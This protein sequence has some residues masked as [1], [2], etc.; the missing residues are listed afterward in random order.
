M[1]PP[2]EQIHAVYQRL[3]AQEADAPSDFIELL[4]DPLIAA[5]EMRFPSLPDPDLISDVVTDTLILFVQTPEQYQP[6]RGSLWHYLF[7]DAWGDIQ[8]AVAKEHRRRTKIVS[9]DPVAHDRADGNNIEEEVV[10]RLEFMSRMGGKDVQAFLNELRAVIPD[11]RDWQVVLFML[12]GERSTSV[13]ATVLGIEHLSITDQRKQVK[14]V[15]DRLHKRLKR[16]GVQ[17]HGH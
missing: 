2:A 12:Q 17:I 15:K 11:P 9:L 10:Q 1:Q 4:L 6:E 13:F 3:L 16:Y 14:K 5:L 7:M 8:N